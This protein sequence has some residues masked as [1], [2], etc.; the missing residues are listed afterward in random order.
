MGVWLGNNQILGPV[1]NVRS[2][3]LL[4]TVHVHVYS[5]EESVVIDIFTAVI[6]NVNLRGNLE[7]VEQECSQSIMFM[8]A[9]C[10][11]S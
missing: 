10:R 2:P 8:H 9:A 6:N 5:I 1:C 7:T 11:V 3:L 4:H